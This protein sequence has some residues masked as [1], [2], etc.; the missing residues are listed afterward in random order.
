MS[1]EV[2]PYVC[3]GTKAKFL[4]HRNH[5][6]EMVLNHLGLDR[7][8][9]IVKLIHDDD[10]ERLEKDHIERMEKLRSKGKNIIDYGFPGLYSDEAIMQ[11]KSQRDRNRHY[12]DGSIVRV[13]VEEFNFRKVWDELKDD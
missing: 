11:F 3:K 6:E 8:N 9:Y 10:E 12:E 4:C 2:I 13:F 5:I 7:E 1:G